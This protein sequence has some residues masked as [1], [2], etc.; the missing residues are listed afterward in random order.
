LLSINLRRVSRFD[1]VWFILS[2]ASRFPA[3]LLNNKKDTNMSNI[4][5]IQVQTIYKK[6]FLIFGIRYFTVTSQYTQ[7]IVDFTIKRVFRF[8]L[9]NI[10]GIVGDIQIQFLKIF[11]NIGAG[12]TEE[13]A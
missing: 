6:E 5:E 10:N 11:I 2:P 1:D 3:A 8:R 12:I 4:S 9:Q 7:H 13:E